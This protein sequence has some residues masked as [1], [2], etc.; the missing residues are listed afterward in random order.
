MKNYL[1]ILVLFIFSSVYSQVS[2]SRISIEFENANI[3][4]VISEI[5]EKTNFKF[6]Y[7][8]E[9]LEE[10]TVS[11]SYI[12]TRFQE[13]LNELFKDSLINY[14]ISEDNKIILT[15]N[16]IIYDEL[17]E[18]F[19][20]ENNTVTTQITSE[21]EELK[22]PV[23]YNEDTSSVVKKL[24]TIRIGKENKNRSRKTFTLSGTIYNATN[25]GGVPELAIVVKGTNIGAVTD[26]AGAYTIELP[27]GVNLIETNSLGFEKVQK[28]II[29]YNNG[30]FDLILSEA[31]EGLEEV[32]VEANADRNVDEVNAGKTQINVKEIRNIPLVLGE[33]DIF[34]VA[35]TL[36]GISSAGEG[37]SGY[38]VRGGKTDQ[39]LVLLDDGIIYNPAHFFG[40]FSAINPFTS[41]QV[42]IYK[43]NI[44]AKFG[45]RLSSVFDIKTKD[46]SVEKLSGEASIGPVTANLVLEIP[47]L[48]EKSAILVGGRATYSDWILRSLDNEELNKSKAS[49]YDFIAKYNHRFDENNDLKVTG[50]Y[51][52]DA[53]SITSDSIYGYSNRLATVN[54]GHKFNDENR[55]ELIFTNSQYKFNIDFDG[56]TNTDFELGYVINE[57][58]LKLNLKHFRNA[59]SI[60]YGF[61]SKIYNVSPGFIDP[62]N[63][64][65][66]VESV[67]VPDEGALE[68]AL[69]ISDIYKVSDELSV[70]AGVRFSIFNALGA[71]A[72][73]IY[74]EG[75]PKSEGTLIETKEFGK[76]EVIKTYAAPEFRVAARYFIKP[77]FSIKGSFNTNYQ[78]IH[79]LSNNTTV[80]PIDTWKLSDIN[81]KPQHAAQYSLGLFK[82]FNEN[83]IELSLEGYYK[84][85]DD[86]LDYK[87]GAQLLLNQNIEREVLQGDGKAY[88]I[89]V[90]LKKTKGRLN[91]WIG[92]T[93]SRSFVRLDGDS[94]EETVN[95]GDFFPS[96]YDKPHDFSVVGNYKLT[97]RYSLSAN[98]VYQTGRPVTIPVGNFVVNGSEFVF[99]S[100]RNSFRIP[101]YYRLDISV[102]IEGNHKIKKFAHSFWNISI[103]NVLGRNNPYSVFFVTEDGE[104]KAYQSS[105]FSIPIPTITYNFRF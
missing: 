81:I 1:T 54:W 12:D 58:E 42:D 80:S 78:Y 83:A 102:N 4:A 76:N 66:I 49:F 52:K 104:I 74:Q 29:I 56:Q 34:K 26:R 99:Y 8:A 71:S 59:H 82:N 97:R 63:S 86:I 53:F 19:F 61:S 92:Y 100:D 55:G 25:G 105:I 91:G 65:S 48:K 5:E 64:E 101:D 73:N 50:Y 103:Y 43:G 40:I 95:N 27:A 30:S 77:D 57:S 45:G 94:P 93:Y 87:V 22:T 18:Q 85:M 37:A 6:Y 89:E 9:W 60:D 31:Y 24:E 47:V 62:K 46:A 33:R 79:T 84:R 14:Y 75:L 69:Y 2:D 36:P 20:E 35:A 17:P 3:E 41:D 44:P 68:S 70:N 32:I 67:T 21:E 38:N 23:F 16:T 28:R 51:S 96:N 88:G 15:K 90:L 10:K 39:N 11:G 13:L 7:I 98:F 72:Q